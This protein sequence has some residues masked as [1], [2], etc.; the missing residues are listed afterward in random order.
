MKP[1]LPM[2]ISQLQNDPARQGAVVFPRET[3]EKVLGR[4]M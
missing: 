4:A 1:G 3:V 2:K